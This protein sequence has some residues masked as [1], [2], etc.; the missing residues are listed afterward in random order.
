MLKKLLSFTKQSRRQVKTKNG[1]NK[2]VM[3][4]SHSNKINRPSRKK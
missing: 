2:T 1:G 4:K 3:V